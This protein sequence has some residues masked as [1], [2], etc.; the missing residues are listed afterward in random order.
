MEKPFNLF[1]YVVK[2]HEE[3]LYEAKKHIEALLNNALLDPCCPEGLVHAATLFLGS[4]EDMDHWYYIDPNTGKD[5]A[6]D[7]CEE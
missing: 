5:K 7:D 3:C 1:R 6:G 4:L 2:E